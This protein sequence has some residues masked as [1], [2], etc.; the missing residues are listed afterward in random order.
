MKYHHNINIEI[1]DKIQAM[2]EHYRTS[3]THAGAASGASP[4][5]HMGMHVGARAEY[6]RRSPL[7]RMCACSLT[8]RTHTHTSTALTVVD[9]DPI[10]LR[11]PTI[12]AKGPTY[13]QKTWRG[14]MGGRAYRNQR[15]AAH[16]IRAE[17][18]HTGAA[19]MEQLTH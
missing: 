13:S 1:S 11:P 17:L 15:H 4:A 10:L 7:G 6:V 19:M 12:T 9:S 16:R 8:A 14:H 18:T 5:G 3:H 2:Q